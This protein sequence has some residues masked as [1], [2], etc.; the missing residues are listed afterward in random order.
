MTS[1]AR[2][3]KRTK[4]HETLPYDRSDTH[5]PPC[6][7]KVHLTI[8]NVAFERRLSSAFVEAN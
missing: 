1:K 2:I 8:R 6:E 4:S 3:K 5:T 7:K